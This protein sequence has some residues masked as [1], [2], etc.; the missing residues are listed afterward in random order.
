MAGNSELNS[1]YNRSSSAGPG[2][3]RLLTVAIL[4]FPCAADDKATMDHRK[5][6]GLV[7]RAVSVIERTIEKD[8]TCVGLRKLH[9]PLRL[10][11]A[12]AFFAAFAPLFSPGTNVTALVAFTALIAARISS[13]VTLLFP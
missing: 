7:N 13:K 12:A 2:S 10:L 3:L 8:L 6:D 4:A 9:A 5:N 11:V 1:A